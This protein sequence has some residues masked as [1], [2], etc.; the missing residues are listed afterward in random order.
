VTGDAEPGGKMQRGLKWNGMQGPEM[1]TYWRVS[2]NYQQKETS[3]MNMA[4][5]TCTWDMLTREIIWQIITQCY[6]PTL[7]CTQPNY[8]KHIVGSCCHLVCL[9]IFIEVSNHTCCHK[10]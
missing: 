6:Q 2:T 10:T 9:N 8:S 1:Y 3:R 4:V 7:E 5:P